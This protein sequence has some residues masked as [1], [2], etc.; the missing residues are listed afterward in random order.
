MLCWS[1]DLNSKGRTASTK[2]HSSDFT[3]LRLKTD[4]QPL[5]L[6]HASE[7]KG[8]PEHYGIGWGYWSW[9]PEGNWSTF[10]HDVDTEKYDCNT[11]HLLVLPW[12]VINIT[13]NS[14][15]V[16]NGPDPSRI[17]VESPHQ[18]KNHDWSHREY[19]M[20]SKKWA[21]INTNY[22]HAT[23]YKIKDCNNE[24]FL[25]TSLWILGTYIKISMLSLF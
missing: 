11:G 7:A 1:R 15:R 2:R 9:L 25:F 4:T 22:D 5:W 20:G 10:P 19:R 16:S 23:S 21:V 12:P 14:G 24:Y 3:G 18:V 8:K 17:K 6:L 13:G